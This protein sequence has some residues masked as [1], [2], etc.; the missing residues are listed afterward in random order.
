M[1]QHESHLKRVPHL[2]EGGNIEELFQ[3]HDDIKYHPTLNSANVGGGCDD[4]HL[5]IA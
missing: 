1:P 5:T 4:N 2:H 3:C